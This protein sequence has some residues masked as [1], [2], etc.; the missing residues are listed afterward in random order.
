MTTTRECFASIVVFLYYVYREYKKT[1]SLFL[2]LL[3]LEKGGKDA[4]DFYKWQESMKKVL[5][6]PCIVTVISVQLLKQPK[7]FKENF[8]V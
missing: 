6:G 8:D 5:L 7:K 2:R 1:P 4:S 3:E